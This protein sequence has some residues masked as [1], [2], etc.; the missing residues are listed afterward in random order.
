MMQPLKKILVAVDLE[1]TTERVLQTAVLLAKSFDARL[2][3]L[4]VIPDLLPGG[5]A[6]EEG[7]ELVAVRLSELKRYAEQEGVVVDNVVVVGGKASY[8]ICQT[9]E[10]KGVNLIVVGASRGR[11]KDI[12][13][14]VTAVR[15]LRNSVKPV[16]IVAQREIARPRS[17]L[18]PVD[19]SPASHRALDNAIRLA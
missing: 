14:G 17:I 15:V 18:C 3:L 10:H 11:K 16:W 5:W 7:R 9:A 12:H 6:D 13:L 19:G 4:H 8:H 1:E 2:V